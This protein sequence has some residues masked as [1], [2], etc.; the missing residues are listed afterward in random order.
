[1]EKQNVAAP[2]AEERVSNY[3]IAKKNTQK[4]FLEYD[5]NE[6]IEKWKLTSDDDFIYVEMLGRAY[7]INRADGDVQ[8]S[9]NEFTDYYE[10]DFNETLTIYDLLCYAK[11]DAHI[12]GDF[13]PMQ[14]LS[15]VK[16]ATSYA[17]EGFFHKEEMELDHREKALADACE[18]LG[19][20]QQ[21]K[22]DVA[23]RIP[24]FK[25]LSVLIQFWSSDEE[26]PASL[27]IYCD[28]NTTSYMHF[29][30]IWYLV[31]H[32]MQRIEKYMGI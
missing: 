7:R 21:G 17:G 12:L 2:N 23:Y 4:I 28:K 16:N 13:V 3:E 22:G 24:V 30:T 32:V 27:N 18:K 6:M 26:F 1:M 5:Q 31:S 19:G 29:E 11:K 15:A 8:G 20:V 14:S 10:A 25:D 9:D